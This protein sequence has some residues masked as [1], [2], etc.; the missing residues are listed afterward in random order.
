MFLPLMSITIMG[1]YNAPLIRVIYAYCIQPVDSTAGLIS[2]VHS[3]RDLNYG[4]KTLFCVFV[5]VSVL[6]VATFCVEK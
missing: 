1:H 5:A 3:I 6:S 2:P 4:S